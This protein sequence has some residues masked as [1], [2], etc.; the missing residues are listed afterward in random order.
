MDDLQF[1][2]ADFGTAPAKTCTGCHQPIARDYYDVNGQPFCPACKASLAQAHGAD[3]GTAAFGRALA[4]GV[5]AGAVGSALY[6]VV[7]RISGYRLSIIAIAVGFLVGRAVRWG[8]GGR[9]GVLYQAMAVVLTYVAI[10][11]SALPF[12]VARSRDSL[13][14]LDIPGLTTYLLGLPIR[15]GFE[16]PMGLVIIGIGLYEA[17]TLTAPVRLAI[18]GPFQAAPPTSLPPVPP[19]PPPPVPPVPPAVP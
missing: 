19:V 15:Q 10:A 2:R 14:L 16:S 7:W 11:F 3:A 5:V 4:A 9:G 18:S 13:G 8:T 6:F 1:E 12:L 17:W